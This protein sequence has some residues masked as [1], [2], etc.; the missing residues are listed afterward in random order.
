M[1]KPPSRP[2]V[3]VLAAGALLS[4]SSVACRKDMVTANP[5]P[6]EDPQPLPG[7]PPIPEVA[8]PPSA[9]PTWDAVASGHPVGATN[10][11]I[12]VLEVTADG[13][14]CFK[15]WQSPMAPD[16]SVF[17]LG[18][19]VLNSAEEARGTEVQCPEDKKAE[20]LAAWTAQQSGEAAPR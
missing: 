10:P 11:P 2:P 14:H 8:Q 18:G 19:R 20:L 13:A 15:A 16:R 4:L 3:R 17:D 7:N 9:L 5:P 12:P 1:N 6:P